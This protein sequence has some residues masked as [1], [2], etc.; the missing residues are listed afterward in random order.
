[1]LKSWYCIVNYVL[2]NNNINLH[3]YRNRSV[4]SNLK[5][6]KNISCEIVGGLFWMHLSHTQCPHKRENAESGEVKGMK[7]R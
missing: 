2:T 6:I 3:T 1:M 5:Q 7:G 4:A